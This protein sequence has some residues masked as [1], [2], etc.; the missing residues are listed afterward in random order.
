M[1]NS[2]ESCLNKKWGYISGG[3]IK[4]KIL[5]GDAASIEVVRR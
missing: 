3:L 1:E 4:L 2:D 5:A